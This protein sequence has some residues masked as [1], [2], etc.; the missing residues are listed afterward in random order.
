MPPLG[1]CL[2]HIAPLA[3]MVTILNETKKHQQNTILT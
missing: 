1:K 3:A 2:R